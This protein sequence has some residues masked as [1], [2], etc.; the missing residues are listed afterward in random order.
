MKLKWAKHHLCECEKFIVSVCAV[1]VLQL[2]MMAVP[3]SLMLESGGQEPVLVVQLPWTV[4]RDLLVSVAG[5]FYKNQGVGY[6]NPLSQTH[7]Q[8]TGTFM[9][10]VHVHNV[11]TNS[12]LLILYIIWLKVCCN[13]VGKLLR[14]NDDFFTWSSLNKCILN[15]IIKQ[16]VCSKHDTVC[17]CAVFT[18]GTFKKKNFLLTLK[19]RVVLYTIY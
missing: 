16:S 6:Q 14:P 8:Y 11:W 19:F 3:R 7:I 1:C 13:K 10:D 15:I 5:L 4:R 2:F 17:G 18:K 12:T 9:T